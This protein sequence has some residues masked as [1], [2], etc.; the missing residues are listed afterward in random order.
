M[1]AH[2]IDYQIFGEEMQYVS[3]ELDPQEVVVA[4]AGSLMMMEQH[5][6]MQTI[7]GDGAQPD[8]GI[9][10]KMLS[11]GKRLLTG[12]SLFMTA[13]THTGSGKAKVAFASPYPG[14][15]IPIDLFLIAFKIKLFEQNRESWAST[16]TNGY[17][18]E[19]RCCR[20]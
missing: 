12:E 5:I 20:N 2:E 17:C 1:N 19:K 13:F 3:V 18:S 14:K 4:E 8:Q 6:E 15:I 11:A 7:F 10:G 9:F 16:G